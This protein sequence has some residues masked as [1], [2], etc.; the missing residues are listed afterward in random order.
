MH[1]TRTPPRRATRA[2]KGGL[3]ISDGHTHGRVAYH[4]L[5]APSPQ[6]P[7]HRMRYT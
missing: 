3:E 6:V 7:H 4:D 1:F 2:Q 5:V